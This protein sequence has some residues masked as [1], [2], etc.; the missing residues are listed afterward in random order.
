VATEITLE[1]ALRDRLNERP[2]VRNI[3]VRNLAPALLQSM[4]IRGPVWNA[5]R[6]EDE[7]HHRR[8]DQ[9]VAALEEAT[10]D[11]APQIRG[12]AAIGLGQLGQRAAVDIARIWLGEV[13][14]EHDADVFL[15]ECAVIAMSMV[16]IAAH[17]HASGNHDPEAVELD[18]EIRAELELLLRSPHEDVRFQV[19]PALIELGGAAFEQV[20]VTALSEEESPEICENHVRALATLDPPGKAA[21]DALAEMLETEKHSLLGFE[22]ALAL[23]AARRPEGGPRLVEALTTREHRDR[24]L[25]A[26]AVLGPRAPE[27][28]IAQL[29]S[30]ATSWTTPGMTRV[31]AAYALA[32][33]DPPLGLAFLEKLGKNVR[34]SIRQ[35]V[36]E[37][38]SNL[39]LLAAREQEGDDPYRGGPKE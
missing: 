27:Q 28:C 16:G 32:R 9:V 7:A 37:A 11:S 34:P 17:E 2:D 8:I 22:T 25:E 21:C 24:A 36:E 12:L 10:E 35:G 4:G 30:M 39:E 14:G 18:R 38:H 1:A 31:R 19:G 13:D 3:A 33:V 5:A 20:I 29:A 15:R 26:L 23:A 6:H